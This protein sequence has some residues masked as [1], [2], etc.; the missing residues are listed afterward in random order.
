MTLAVAAAIAVATVAASALAGWL[1]AGRR[2]RALECEL[3]RDPL[4]GVGNRRA[5]ERT[6][7]E[8][9]L[10]DAGSGR[11]HSLVMIDLD[12]FKRL[13]DSLGH[14]TGDEILALVARH[15]RDV[16]RE[17]AGVNGSVFRFG[18]D[19][20]A[21][22]LRGW[23]PVHAETLVEEM[24][25]RVEEEPLTRRSG[26]RVSAGV[27]SWPDHA[28]RVEALVSLADRALYQ[29]KRAGR[30]RT[31]V[32]SSLSAATAEERGDH[33]AQLRVLAGVLAAAVDAKDAYTHAH[34]HNV[35]DLSGYIARALG[36]DEQTIDEVYLGGLLHDVGKIGVDDVIL[37]KPGS[38]EPFEWLEV[39]EHCEIGYRIL[40]SIEGAERIRDIVLYH[41]ERVEGGGY[42][43]G[44]H[45]DD[46]PIGARIVAVADAFDSITADR[47]YRRSVSPDQA[48]EEI[49][50]CRGT[51]FD[52]AV[53]DALCELMLY[54]PGTA[55]PIELRPAA[56]ARDDDDPEAEVLDAAA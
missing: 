23:D 16:V 41:H 21:L 3:H 13:N 54:E 26:V 47:V 4:T 14:Q 6:L 37:T 1:V 43:T 2:M 51:Q 56:S 32:Y 8:T 40:N 35:A 42:P 53:V 39:K 19:E 5:F 30:N 29:A 17:R 24:R 28:E 15:F 50:R 48:L 34:S 36:L 38:L 12:G 22:L 11:W 49:V 10:E 27:A 44:I 20:F 25:Q 33:L 55:E 9:E 7:L 46:I 18:G 45:G 52:P 31:I